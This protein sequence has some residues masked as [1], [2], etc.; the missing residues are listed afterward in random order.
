MYKVT[1]PHPLQPPEKGMTIIILKLQLSVYICVS[2]CLSTLCQYCLPLLGA[3]GVKEK[4]YNM[5]KH[6]H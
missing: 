6:D 5:A 4:F 3:T 2:V 1:Y